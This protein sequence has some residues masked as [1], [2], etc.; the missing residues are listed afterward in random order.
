[1]LFST[2]ASFN[3]KL[4]FMENQTTKITA[5]STIQEIFDDRNFNDIIKNEISSIVNQP[6]PA[7]Y[8]RKSGIDSFFEE[9][10]IQIMKDSFTEILFK[11]SELPS[12]KR[13]MIERIV[14]TSIYKTIEYYKTK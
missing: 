1:M 2:L 4:K 7:G 8:K 13:K 11:K 10:D 9:F 14:T 5:E 12:F 6:I 3:L